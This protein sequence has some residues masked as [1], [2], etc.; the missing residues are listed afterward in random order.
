[1]PRRAPARATLAPSTL[2]A[3]KLAALLAATLAS[4]GARAEVTVQGT[5][6]ASAG[7]TDNI[8]GAPDQ[9]TANGPPREGDFLFQLVPGV[10]LSSATPRFIERAAYSFTADLF[11]THSEANSYSNTIDWAG[12]I[13]TSP[14][15]TMILT[16]E[17][18]QGKLS[19]FSFNQPSAGAAITVLPQNNDVNYFRQIASESFVATPTAQWRVSQLLSF[20]AFVPLTQGTLATSYDV[21]GEV[22]VDRIFRLDSLGLLL[23]AELIDFVQPRDPTTD[24]PVAFD[25]RQELTTLLARWRRDW[26]PSWSTEASLGAISIVSA[27]SDPMA[28]TS[29]DWEP[30]ARA[31]VR[32]AQKLGSAELRYAHDVEPNALLG[33]TFSTDV[34]ALQAGVPIVRAKLSFGATAAYEHVRL[35]S[36]GTGGPNDS[37]DLALVDFTV[38]WQLR[39][40][41]QLFA[42]Y[43]LL[44][45]FGSPPMSGAASVL[46]DLTRNLVMIGATVVYPA[47][48]TVRVPTRQGT[49]VD[50]SDQAAFP[51]V[52]APAP[53]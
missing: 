16:L 41:L 27:S 51:E 21:A 53:R 26:S 47:V 36:Q 15:S 35:L 1:M 31:A 3:V 8:L 5:G 25:Q 38:G 23:R 43:S 37:A 39:P 22:G 28:T 40:E 4:A 2:G 7:W 13:L 9:P 20:H 24:V 49:R 32:W 46:P 34:V 44:D 12:N 17:S 10:V 50:G 18:Q 6:T 30:S 14:T 52:H 11:A 33:T 48:M 29:S 42:R 45:Q 19:T